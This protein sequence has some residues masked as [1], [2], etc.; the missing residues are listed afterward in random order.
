MKGTNTKREKSTLEYKE[1]ETLLADVGKAR[2]K[3]AVEAWLIVG[4]ARRKT[5]EGVK[6]HVEKFRVQ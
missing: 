5:R 1:W 6:L 4:N 2:Q 3:I